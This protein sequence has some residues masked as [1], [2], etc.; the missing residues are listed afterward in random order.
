M[1]AVVGQRLG[2]PFLYS[3]SMRSPSQR[4][5]TTSIGSRSQTTAISRRRSHCSG[6]R[7]AGTRPVRLGFFSESCAGR[8]IGGQS[9]TAL[10]GIKVYRGGN[11]LA[12]RN[13][14]RLLY[15]GYMVTEPNA[16]LTSPLPNEIFTVFPPR[17]PVD[18]RKQLAGL[19]GRWPLATGL[20]GKKP[21]TVVKRLKALFFGLAGVG[22]T[23][24]AI[25]FPRP[26][27]I[28]CEKGAEND[29]YVKI[30]DAKGGAYMGPE[31]G[32]TNLDEIIREV[33]TLL[34]VSHPYRTLIIDPLTVPYNDE[35]DKCAKMLV[36]SEDKL[37]TA[38]Q[39]HKQPADRKL[40][41]LLNL[42]LRLDMNVL[43]TSHAKGEWKNGAPT[44]TDTFDCYA[45]LEYLF[46]LVVLIQKRGA[47][48]VGIVRKT[49]I[50]AF[51]EGENFPFT[52]DIIAD[53]YGRE[54]LERDAQAESLATSEQVAALNAMLADRVDGEKLKEKWLEKAQAD[55]ISELPAEVAAKCINYLTQA[56]VAAA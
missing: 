18:S 25:Q 46:D 39:R 10:I 41:H 35:L 43:I 50:D 34:S 13:T 15:R 24:A 12:I 49:R 54:I 31:E 11:R 17:P 36:T 42:L 33:T 52:Y 51:P 47:E 20:R 22:K 53:K 37:G 21:K 45:K 44:G 38:F 56:P 2:R 3:A 8:A 9:S 7:R 6:V 32:S 48:R 23:T 27:L 30:L 26:Y 4:P 1:I 40:K 55:A 19:K 14:L 5:A 28:D 29:Q 16:Y